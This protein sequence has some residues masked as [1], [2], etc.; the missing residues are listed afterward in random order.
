MSW[1]AI[2]RHCTGLGSIGACV[3]A[4]S[5]VL[6]ICTAYR[7][8]QWGSATRRN[9]TR[10]LPYCLSREVTQGEV[11]VANR[12]RTIRAMLIFALAISILGNQ[13]MAAGAIA[14]DSQRRLYGSYGFQTASEADQRAMNDCG[15]TCRIVLRFESGCA[16]YADDQSIGSTVF[17][18]AKESSEHSA[19]INA[20]TQCQRHGGA[21]CKVRIWVCD[22][23]KS[24][25]RP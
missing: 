17:G 14:I 13:A 12:S 22:P 4:F 19:K 25:E 16:A 1:H 11:I 23:E 6:F 20:M 24:S 2:V 8:R 18:W 5:V 9:S 7:W 3:N 15:Y 21:M 10:H